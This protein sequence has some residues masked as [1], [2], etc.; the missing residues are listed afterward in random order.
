[1]KQLMDEYLDLA[2]VAM[3]GLNEI[4][5]ESLKSKTLY[6]ILSDFPIFEEQPNIKTTLIDI[7]DAH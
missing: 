7:G 6:S 1:M 4:A 3:I 5:P 2:L